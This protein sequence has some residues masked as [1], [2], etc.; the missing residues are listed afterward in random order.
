MFQ[1]NATKKLVNEEREKIDFSTKGV[2]SIPMT[3]EIENMV[4][5]TA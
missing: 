3:S 1:K 5:Y 2:I 4:L